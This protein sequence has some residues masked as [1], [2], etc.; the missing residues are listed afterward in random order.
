MNQSEGWW[1]S[2]SANGHTKYHYF[3]GAKSLCGWRFE[4]D[5]T[6]SPAD[7]DEKHCAVCRREL[8]NL[9]DTNDASP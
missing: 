1:K 8:V 7:T 6:R 4:G 5:A 9:K 2:I 3:V